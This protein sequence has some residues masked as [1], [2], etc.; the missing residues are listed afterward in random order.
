MYQYAFGFANLF[1]PF[2][3]SLD[4][5]DH[6]DDVPVVAVGGGGGVCLSGVIVVIGVIVGL[7]V[8]LKFLL[9]F[10]KCPVWKLT[11]L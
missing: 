4:V 10:V 2:S 8:P 6:N 9:K 5:W 1:K 11:S 7:V 3:C